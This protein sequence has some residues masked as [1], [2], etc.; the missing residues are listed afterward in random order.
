LAYLLPRL[1]PDAFDPGV[2]LA[3]EFAA[4][5]VGVGFHCYQFDEQS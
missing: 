3:V 1:L 4:F 2:V 5:E